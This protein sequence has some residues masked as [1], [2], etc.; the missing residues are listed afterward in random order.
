[1]KRNVCQKIQHAMLVVAIIPMLSG[2]CQKPSPEAGWPEINN[3]TKPWT[4]WWWQGNSLQSETLPQVMTKYH[5]AGLGG[6]EITPIYGVKGYE[7]Q[8]V[9]YLSPKWMGLLNQTL[10]IADSLNLGIDMANTSGWPFGGPWIGPRHA[11]KRLVYK[12]YHFTG[13]QDIRQKIIYEQKPLAR[14]VRKNPDISDIRYPVSKTDSLQQL[15][16]AQVRF[17]GKL[18]LVCLMAYSN[19]EDIVNITDQVNENGKLIWQV[20]PGEWD[21]YAVFQGWHGK[22]VERASPGGEGNVIDHFSEAALK[23][24]LHAFDTAFSGEDIQSIRAFFNDS[25]EV[26][27]ALGESNFTPEFLE[28][29]QQRRGYD[30]RK[31]LPALFG[32]TS[33]EKHQRVLCDYRETISELLLEKFTRPWKNWAHENNALIRNQAHGSPANILDLYGASDIPETEGTDLMRIKFASSAAHLTG[34]N[35]T[36]AEACTWLD[37]HFQ[38][39]LGDVKKNIDRYLLGGVNHIV[40]HGTPYS[41]P[42]E[43]WP[44]WLFYAAVHFGPTNPFWHDFPALNHYVTRCQS[45]L[46]TGK[47]DNDLLVYFPV[48]DR[49]SHLSD[50]LLEHFDGGAEGTS[51]RELGIKLHNQGYTFDFVSD[52]QITTLSFKNEQIT[53]QDSRYQAIVVPQTEYM[54]I[55]TIQHLYDLANKGAKIIFAGTMHGDV[56]GFGNL[57]KRQEQYRE[58]KTKLD[59]SSLDNTMDKA[60]AGKGAFFKGKPVNEILTATGVQPEPMVKDSLWFIRRKQPHGHT[61]FIL[62]RSSKKVDQWVQLKKD[63]S[64]VVLYNPMNDRYGKAATRKDGSVYFQLRPGESC[65]LETYD[66]AAVSADNYPYW[67]KAGDSMSIKKNWKVSFEDGGPQMPPRLETKQLK[68]WT[69]MGGDLYKRFS[70]TA[71]Y[72]I[73]LDASEIPDADAWMLDLGKVGE[74]AE[75]HWNGKKLGTTIHPPHHLV[76]NEHRIEKNNTLE[77]RVSNLMANRIAY[78]DREGVYWK[79]FYNI[80]FPARKPENRDDDGLFTA[81]EW[82]PFGSGLMG[83]VSLTPL[84]RKTF[85]SNTK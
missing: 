76:V 29:F 46:Q 71:S 42:D 13:D 85:S 35:L 6:L 73:I 7:D 15:A 5:Q 56:P 1:M 30:L 26:D 2:G 24:H 78:M 52:R 67:E 74:S 57:E 12:K 77:I 36:S 84:Q 54:P 34:K 33:K 28:A 50:R 14:A 20:P 49:W 60:G 18:P 43:Q 16:L 79:K 70:G 40:Y 75:V 61:Y 19:S 17:P 47:P 38:A 25:Y 27:D 72:T 48:Y 9:D 32:E 62:N 41:P 10:N 51:A 69:E 53:A 55:E 11:C 23:Q 8:F 44:G 80:N 59:F 3:E 58:F 31:H 65:I 66:K 4:R 64:S 82:E 39:T 37:E 21:V 68:S 22:M 45:F 63:A 83:Q 81:E